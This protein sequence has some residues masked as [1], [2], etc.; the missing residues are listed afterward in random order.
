MGYT[1]PAQP[2]A[3]CEA[4]TSPDAVMAV[5]VA[6]PRVGRPMDTHPRV[7]AHCVSPPPTAGTTPHAYSAHL[8]QPQHQVRRIH[9][10]ARSRSVRGRD[11]SLSRLG[12]RIVKAGGHVGWYDAGGRSTAH[13]T[14]ESRDYRE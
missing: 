9:R 6:H 11:D 10:A 5:D 3:A 2:T 13:R 1:A 12:V 8:P 7:G 4:L 14:A